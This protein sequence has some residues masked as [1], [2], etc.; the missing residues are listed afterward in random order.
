M[1]SQ[2][3]ESEIRNYTALGTLI[4]GF[5][6]AVFGI[7]L[8]LAVENFAFIGV[9]VAAGTGVGA[10]IGQSIRRND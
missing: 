7:L 1:N 9:G 3:N 10:A 8:S 2:P 5:L 6:G 4:G